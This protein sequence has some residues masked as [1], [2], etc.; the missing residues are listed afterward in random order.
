[1]DHWG[2]SDYPDPVNRA[3]FHARA[4]DPIAFEDAVAGLI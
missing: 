1:M 2:G 3:V 4:D